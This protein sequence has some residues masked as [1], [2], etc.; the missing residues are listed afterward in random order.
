MRGG[1]QGMKRPTLYKITQIHKAL[2]VVLHCVN[3]QA[4]TRVWQIE[5]QVGTSKV[6]TGIGVL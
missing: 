1:S 3:N 6:S 2:Y 4:V 5:E